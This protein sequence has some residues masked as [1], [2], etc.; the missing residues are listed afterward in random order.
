[1]KALILAAGYATRLY[2]LTKDR[3]KPLLAI[4]GKPILEY[5]MERL[6]RVEEI[7][8]VYLVTNKKFIPN[9]QNWLANFKIKKRVKTLNN[10]STCDDNK[11]GAIGDIRFVLEKERIDDDLLIIAGDNLFEFDLSRFIRF[12]HEK[13][14][15]CIALYDIG[16]KERARKYGVVAIDAN[17]RIVNFEE[18]PSCPASTLIATCL[19]L[20]SKKDLSLISTYLKE[21]RSSDAPGFY[22]QWLAEKEEVYGFV[23][24]EKWY[25]IGSLESLRE[26]DSEYRKKESH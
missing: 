10:G 4:A 16:D 9:F 22:I 15:S 14:A 26:A 20:F 7:E 1:M 17:Q 5:I 23:F 3:P 11:L 18:K 2:P 24:K 6:K 21:K 13:K 8:A 19:Y 25:D 12:F